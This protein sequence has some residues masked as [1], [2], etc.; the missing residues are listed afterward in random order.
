MQID[1][2]IKEELKRYLLDKI[3]HKQLPKV[4]IRAAYI[5]SSE[6]IE[7]LKERFEILQ[8]AKIIT[9]V[10]DDILAGFMIQ[11]DSQIID[12]TLDKQLKSLEYTLYETA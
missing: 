6:E 12:L 7:M 11:F 9:E 1:P 4:T 3:Q 8:H 2:V 5:L 10:S